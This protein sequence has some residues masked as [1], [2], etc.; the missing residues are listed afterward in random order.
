MSDGASGPERRVVN[1]V[2]EVRVG[3]EWVKLVGGPERDFG[4]RPGQRVFIP[5]AARYSFPFIEAIRR[6]FGMNGW[7]RKPDATD[8]EWERLREDEWRDTK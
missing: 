6:R 2:W 5:S 8:D 7:R 3:S 4:M 1:G